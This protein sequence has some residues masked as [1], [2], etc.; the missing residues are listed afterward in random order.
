MKPKT[1]GPTPDKRRS[2]LR[3]EVKGLNVLFTIKEGLQDNLSFTL[4]CLF[5]GSLS[6]TMCHPQ[7][8]YD[9]RNTILN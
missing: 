2:E 6:Q 1:V 8:F 5:R 7:K 4:L 3:D 9:L